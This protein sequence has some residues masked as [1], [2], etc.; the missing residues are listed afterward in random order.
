MDLTLDI[1]TKPLSGTL[2]LAGDKSLAHR[3]ALFA[4]L[5]EG[6]SS[7]SNYPDS[8]VTRAMRR[9]LATLGVPSTLEDGILRIEGRGYKP[10]SPSGTADCGNS[11]TTIRLLAG[12]I[13]GTR[14]SAILDGSAGLRKRPMDRIAE[15]L[16]QMGAKVTTAAGCAPLAFAPAQTLAPLSYALPV[17]S[18]QVKSCLILAALGA[19]GISHI[20][21]PGPSRDHTELMLR[22]MGAHI[23]S[24]RLEVEVHPL[25]RPLAP[26]SGTLPGDISSAAFLFAAAAIV[27]GS[28][29]TVANLGVNPTRTGILDVLSAMGCTV[30]CANR[31]KVFGEDVADVTVSSPATLRAVEISGDLVVRS[32]DEFPAIA[33]AAAFATGVTTVRDAKELRYK[34]S[35]R[36][37]AICRN[38]AALGAEV[39]ELDDGFTIAGLTISGGTA[40]AGGD[41][42]LAMSMALTGLRV[43]TTVQDAEILAESFPGFAQ[44]I[45]SLR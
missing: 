17:A 29:V 1:A 20:S 24:R 28:C 26:L 25:S 21:E 27:P 14:S 42:R 33:A 5:A 7:V 23:V 6:T 16:A 13:A 15:P 19:S 39:A 35:D 10:F 2:S 38:L 34:E 30:I 41:H 3:A 9:A 4:A 43:H 32:I 40:K 37:S 45:D 12:A 44:T 31:R 18:A 8:G 36:I 11:G 22:S